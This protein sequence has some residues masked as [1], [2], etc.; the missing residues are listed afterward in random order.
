MRT[1]LLASCCGLAALAVSSVSA[2]SQAA[3]FSVSGASL[4]LRGDIQ[5]GDQFRFQ[6]ALARPEGTHVRQVNLASSG[7][8]IQAAQEIGRQIRA[9]GLTTVVDAAR[10]RCASACSLIFLSGARR[11]YLHADGVG[12]ISHSASFLGLGFHQGAQGGTH[13]YSG[14][15]T[16][17]QIAICHE[18]GLP[19]A[20]QLV[21]NAP[22]SAIYGLSGGTALSMGIATALSQ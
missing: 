8:S 14:E 3:E 10:D 15:G 1:R 13:S 22:P 7:G 18:F 20:A 6:Q 2:P 12:G 17:Q 11:I 16:A 5:P 4:W 9:A 21:E 19:Q